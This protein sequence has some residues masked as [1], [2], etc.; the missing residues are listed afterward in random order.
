MY[1]SALLYCA[2]FMHRAC[3][4]V[5]MYMHTHALCSYTRHLR[6][7]R[8]ASIHVNWPSGISRAATIAVNRTQGVKYGCIYRHLPMMYT[9]LCCTIKPKKKS[10]VSSLCACCVRPRPAFLVNNAVLVLVYLSVG[11]VVFF[12]PAVKQCPIAAKI[13]GSI[14]IM[15]C[16]VLKRFSHRGMNVCPICAASLSRHTSCLGI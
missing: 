15:S 14:G 7:C 4:R 3:V 11:P 13:A 1:M 2:I 6:T 9:P 16:R 12:F 10:P 8:Y 5:H